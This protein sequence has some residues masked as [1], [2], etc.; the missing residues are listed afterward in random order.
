MTEMTLSR[1][2]PDDTI[3]HLT[4]ILYH[5]FSLTQ[6]SIPAQHDLFHYVHVVNPQLTL[7]PETLIRVRGEAAQIMYKR[8][9]FDETTWS[10]D[11]THTGLDEYS[12]SR[13]LRE[14]AEKMQ[15]AFAL[16]QPD[17]E[18]REQAI[19][20]FHERFLKH[21]LQY[22]YVYLVAR[23]NGR[24]R[25]PTRED[26]TGLYSPWLSMFHYYA[27]EQHKHPV[28]EFAELL[29]QL[30]KLFIAK[31]QSAEIFVNPNMESRDVD[32]KY[33]PDELGLVTSLLAKKWKEKHGKDFMEAF[34]VLDAKRRD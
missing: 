11:G 13:A 1:E 12:F 19:Q 23:E 32:R 17:S 20:N 25:G 30:R 33:V 6:G 7:T 22:D 10:R 2:T 21:F 8:F 28:P 31:V 18:H 14:T 9:N 15:E 27:G 4:Q 26:D 24:P 5:S 3:R 16:P 34:Q 29:A